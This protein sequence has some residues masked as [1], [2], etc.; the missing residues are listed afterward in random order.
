MVW[1]S[2]TGLGSNTWRLSWRIFQLH[3]LPSRWKWWQRPALWNEIVFFLQKILTSKSQVPTHPRIF[4]IYDSN[5]SPCSTAIST[6][7]QQFATRGMEGVSGMM[8]LQ[9]SDLMEPCDTYS[10]RLSTLHYQV[11]PTWKQ[12]FFRLH[13]EEVTPKR[14]KLMW[15]GKLHSEAFFLWLRNLNGMAQPYTFDHC[16]VGHVAPLFATLQVFHQFTHGT[17]ANCLDIL[18]AWAWSSPSW[19]ARKRNHHEKCRSAAKVPESVAERG[20][21]F[22][23]RSKEERSV[24]AVVALGNMKSSWSHHEVIWIWNNLD[25]FFF[26]HVKRFLLGTPLCSSAKTYAGNEEWNGISTMVASCHCGQLWLPGAAPVG[27]DKGRLKAYFKHLQTFSNIFKHLQTII[28]TE[29]FKNE[30]YESRQGRRH[31]SKIFKA[32]N[33]IG[34]QAC[35]AIAA[36]LKL[37]VESRGD[38][39]CWNCKCNI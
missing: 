24:L 28:K 15:L 20:L 21:R 9:T 19:Q 36:P 16:S 27:A 25:C 14:C 26:S 10:G 29:Y 32:S 39:S 13:W 18:C 11:P 37:L 31:T 17:L 2:A 3:W 5:R 1:L 22:F 35:I 33:E 23:N 8:Q 7:Q 6:S 30:F 4:S 38:I 12:F 34:Y